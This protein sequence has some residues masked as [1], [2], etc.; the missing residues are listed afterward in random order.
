MGSEPDCF[1]PTFIKLWKKEITSQNLPYNQA[2]QIKTGNRLRPI[3]M[4][5]GYYANCSSENN[6]YIADYAIS[7]ELLH[8][9]SILLDD[10]I[11]ADVARHEKDTFHIQYS[12]SD[13]L[14]YAIYMLNRSITLI[15]QKDLA[16]NCL[17]TPTLLKII[18]NMVR[19]GIKEI[20]A[21]NR[22]F[23]LH[24][25]KEI[26]DLETIS[27][28]ENSF[29]LGYQLSS[30]DPS[31]IPE[32][33]KKIGKLCGYCFQVLNDIEPFSDPSINQIYKGNLNN[34]FEKQRKNIVISFLYGACTQKER[35]K[36]I[37]N[38]DYVEI[39]KLLKKY[40]ILSILLAEVE[41]EIS[42]IMQCIT[43]LQND[44][45]TFYNEFKKFLEN[46]FKICYQKCS[47]PFKEELFND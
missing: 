21:N 17:H 41:T 25:V 7:I 36:L 22:I 23:S 18:D 12:E 10:L 45:F 42:C 29:M 13:A 33:I 19:G 15:Y 31:Y 47:L 1:L 27:L 14:L 38:Y 16:N 35:I 43:Y 20:G 8:K 6:L 5:W 28:I 44:N 24:D 34:D 9:S 2:L 3:L 30:N 11:D 32:D 4:A 37:N 26:I 40:N 46:M 39:C